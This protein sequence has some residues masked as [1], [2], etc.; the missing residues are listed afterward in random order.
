MFVS[1]TVI[2]RF[3]SVRMR[4]ANLSRFAVSKTTKDSYSIFI[5]EM[6]ISFFARYI[7]ISHEMESYS[8]RPKNIKVLLLNSKILGGILLRFFFFFV[9]YIKSMLI[10]MCGMKF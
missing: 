10:E 9:Q 1:K 6:K 2:W 7:L 4:R 3:Q 5:I 8:N